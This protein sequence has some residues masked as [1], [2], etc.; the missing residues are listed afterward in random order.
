M[1]RTARPSLFDTTVGFDDPLEMLLACHR[2]IEKQLETLKRLRAHLDAGPMGAEASR[3]AQAVLRYFQRSA[4]HHHD[5]EEKDVFPLLEQRI[6]DPVERG[7]FAVLRAELER[8]HRQIESHWARI[9]K[10]L[11][12]IA[13]GLP[14]ILPASDVH[15]FVAVYAR[16]ILA[17][18]SALQQF[19]ERWLN[20][21]DRR[22]LG[23][24][25][26][27]RRSE[28]YPPNAEPGATRRL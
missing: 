5:D 21:D 8:D 17:E 16:H 18:E 7:R 3:A 6:T 12:G 19:F 2:R 14:R 4:L 1:K 15:A 13:E 27:A 11:D 25:M 26:S 23:R 22:E 20:E 9:K 28:P 24:S 10:P